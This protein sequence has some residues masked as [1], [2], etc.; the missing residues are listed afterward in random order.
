MEEKEYEVEPLDRPLP[1]TALVATATPTFWDLEPAQ[2]VDVVVRSVERVLV[3][4]AASIRDVV[5]GELDVWRGWAA[6]RVP[7]V[8]LGLSAHVV[9]E[10]LGR[11]GRH[12]LPAACVA[13][14]TQ[15]VETLA[16]LGGAETETR[17]RTLLWSARMSAERAAWL[18]G[19]R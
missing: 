3:R 17:R 16:R 5:R 2:L 18:G 4:L 15:T 6:G 7:D 12:D 1:A 19:R 11:G 10:A 8:R 9:R 14:A 13:V